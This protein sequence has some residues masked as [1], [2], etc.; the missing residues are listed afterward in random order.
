MKMP[1][2]RQ[3][4]SKHIAEYFPHSVSQI[5]TRCPSG[6]HKTKKKQQSIPLTAACIRDQ[7]PL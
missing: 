3:N 2:T 1:P 4:I 5:N 6:H 7:M